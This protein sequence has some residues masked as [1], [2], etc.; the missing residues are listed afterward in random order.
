MYNNKLLA[1]LYIR[2][3][4]LKIVKEIAYLYFVVKDAACDIAL[5]KMNIKLQYI[6]KKRF[7]KIIKMLHDEKKASKFINIKKYKKLSLVY[8]L[9]KRL[10]RGELYYNKI[11]TQIERNTIN[12][13]VKKDKI[14]VAFITYSTSVW[15]GDELYTILR[16][17]K[18]FEPYILVMANYN[19]QN[20]RMLEE[21]YKK[22]HNFYK[23]K[24]MNI[25]DTY[26]IH[27]KK[28]KKMH[29]LNIK[30]DVCIWMTPW[31]NVFN[32]DLRIDRFFLNTLHTYIP[33]GFMIADNVENTFVY[34][35]Y[36]LKIHNL[37][38]KDF[39]ESL[40]SLKMAKKY[41]FLKGKNAVYTGYPKMD[42]YF[43]KE[44]QSYNVWE[45]LQRR[46]GNNSAKK[47]IYA[48]HHSLDIEDE[49]CFSTFA[50]NY[51]EIIKLARK[52][53]EETVWVFRPHPLLKYKAILFGLFK[54][55]KEW[56][57][58]ENEW[59]SLENAQVL[60]D[61]EYS[62]LFKNSDGMILDSVS[63]LAEYLY[64]NKPLLF[65]KRTEQRFNDFGQ[66]LLGVH[67]T[68]DGKDIYSINKFIKN[69]IINQQDDNYNVRKV[70]FE[71][72]LNYYNA[73]G[74]NAAKNIYLEI[75]H[76]LIGGK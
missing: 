55:E 3:Q 29:N 65:L 75:E 35:Q 36:N 46:I 26:D 15:I 34:H 25:I 69:V 39:E 38:W 48:P 18:K 44:E 62:S 66:L 37:V 70:F 1:K 14:I 63:F 6:I 33:Y 24:N 30:P 52:Y 71:K 20:E 51:R 59:N 58:Y 56:E 8:E 10:D 23:K 31:I 74:E 50:V 27:K 2:H 7:L 73:L 67:Y 22:L 54:D 61:G 76:G 57:M 40:L 13:I 32:R 12:E 41:N 64:V 72:Y 16:K 42:K 19:G 9:S 17:S 45:E 68:C 11:K 47:I 43:E 21:E 4:N 60:C 28:S 49:V 53:K 5:D